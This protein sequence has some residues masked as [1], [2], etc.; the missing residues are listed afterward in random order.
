M[1][2][3]TAQSTNDPTSRDGDGDR[4]PD[5]EPSQYP[6]PDQDSHPLLTSLPLEDSE[7]LG[8]DAFIFAP[9]LFLQPPPDQESGGPSSSSSSPSPSQTVLIGETVT[10]TTTTRI[11]DHHGHECGH[12]RQSDTNVAAEESSSP[13]GEPRLE[14]TASSRAENIS[15]G[16]EVFILDARGNSIVSTDAVDPAQLLR[17]CRQQNDMA[18][19]ADCAAHPRSRQGYTCGQGNGNGN[20][21]SASIYMMTGTLEIQGVGLAY[22]FVPTGAVGGRARAA[23]R[24]EAIVKVR[25]RAGQ[26]V[27]YT[28]DGTEWAALVESAE[29][30]DHRRCYNLFLPA[31]GSGRVLVTDEFLREV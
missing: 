7:D 14:E 23:W 12:A 29:V 19:L 5:P 8:S 13:R 9:E 27:R 15:V 20:G 2:N 10:T 22:H 21:T 26:H 25:F 11:S 6:S 31:S 18:G 1:D 17:V 16:D 28:E 24:R 3:D 4:S 30:V